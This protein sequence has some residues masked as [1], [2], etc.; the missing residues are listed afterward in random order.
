MKKRIAFIGCGGLA[1]IVFR[2]YIDGKL[3]EYEITGIYGVEKESVQNWADK[4]KCTPYFELEPM[5]E[6]KPDFIIEMAS[7]EAGKNAVLKVLNAGID[8]IG[9]SV[10]ILADDDFREKVYQ[11][12]SETG[13]KVLIPSG[14]VGGFD[15]LKTISLMDIEYAELSM[16]KGPDTM[17]GTSI[18]TDDWYELKENTVVFEGNAREA[19]ELMPT[20]INIGVATALATLGIEKTRIRILIRSDMHDDDI[21]VIAKSK[22]ASCTYNF[23]S[24]PADVAGWSIVALLQNIASPVIF[25]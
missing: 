19:I 21:T 17:K 9:L 22:D 18:Y 5:I 11:T 7:V 14:S 25:L 13:R 20:K 4:V 23:F 12:A 3:P 16:V 2:S 8:Y 6:T 24:K 15:M 1:S 10:G